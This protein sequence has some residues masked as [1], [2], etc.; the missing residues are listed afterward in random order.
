MNEPHLFIK[1]GPPTSLKFEQPKNKIFLNQSVTDHVAAHFQYYEDINVERIK[2]I[3]VNVQYSD[4]L[5]DRNR[6]LTIQLVSLFPP[7]LAAKAAGLDNCYHLQAFCEDGHLMQCQMR[8]IV[9]KGNTTACGT[10]PF[11]QLDKE[12]LTI[13][14]D[15]VTLQQFVPCLRQR[16]IARRSLLVDKKQFDKN[17]VELQSHADPQCSKI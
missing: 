11:W 5:A 7:V 2:L 1:Y 14:L 15:D 3:S 16:S 17:G 8:K 10:G 4:C 9:L 6:A 13:K 12:H